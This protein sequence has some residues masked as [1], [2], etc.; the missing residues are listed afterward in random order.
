M[1][2]IVEKRILNVLGDRIQD[3]VFE[4]PVLEDAAFAQFFVELLDVVDLFLGVVLNLVLVL[5]HYGFLVGL[6]VEP[7]VFGV[8]RDCVLLVQLRVRI[9]QCFS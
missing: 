1:N 9:M 7:R 6:L 5:L 2:F 4:V 8:N 3:L